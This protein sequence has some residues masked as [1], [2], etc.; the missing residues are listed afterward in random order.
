MTSFVTVWT[1]PSTA[2]VESRVARLIRASRD[3]G[4][5]C[6]SISIAGHD[7]PKC[8]ELLNQAFRQLVSLSMSD[9]TLHIVAVI[10]LY[11]ADAE[12]EESQGRSVFI[13]DRWYDGEKQEAT[14]KEKETDISDI[15]NLLA[16]CEQR[17]D[18]DGGDAS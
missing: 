12:D 4:E 18:E 11:E 1:S 14:A 2:N 17:L 13:N 9:S 15:A 5:A 3:A 16:Y 6:D 8:I 10:P 7:T